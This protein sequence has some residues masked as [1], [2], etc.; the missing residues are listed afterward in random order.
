MCDLAADAL[1]DAKAW[2][3]DKLLELVQEGRV[4]LDSVEQ[5]YNRIDATTD[6]AVAAKH[7]DL[8]SESVR[9]EV[10]VKRDV[11]RHLGPLCPERTLFTTNSSYIAPSLIADACGRPERFAALHFHKNVWH[12]NV[13]DIMPHAGTSPETTQLL[14]EF[15]KQIDQIPV[16]VRN[17]GSGHVFNALI[18]PLMFAAL[19]L[20]EKEVASVE[21]IDRVW[22]VV[23][24]NSPGLFGLMDM[25]GLDVLRDSG[26][27]INRIH[28]DP[29]KE[30]CIAYLEKMI[31]AG[32]LGVKSGR[33]FYSYPNPA[34][35]RADFL[36]TATPSQPID[37]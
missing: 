31:D 4:S 11:W 18:H 3:H 16:V 14:V 33:G 22:M 19:T 13:T 15:A 24:K 7:A 27:Y 23:M 9:E 26:R 35:E 29:Q 25:I 17:E 37:P 21:D 28:P 8:V 5:I 12:S 20:A 2:Q 6:L 32:R 1:T 30:K 10:E 34:F 36:N